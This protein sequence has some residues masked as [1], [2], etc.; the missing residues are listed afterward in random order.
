LISGNSLSKLRQ[1]SESLLIIRSRHGG[2]KYSRDK[3]TQTI[4]TP[5]RALLT[6]KS[7]VA[8]MICDDPAISRNRRQAKARTPGKEAVNGGNTG[9]PQATSLAGLGI[10]AE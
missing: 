3:I 4:S 9:A 1:F 8:G 10:C 6:Q 2:E 7:P 5:H